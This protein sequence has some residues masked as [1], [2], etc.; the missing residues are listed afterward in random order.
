[1][2]STRSRRTF[3]LV[4]ATATLPLALT[5]CGMGDSE[6]DSSKD[7]AST[8]SAEKE[9]PAEDSADGAA[10]ASGPFGPGC[11]S[12]PKDGAGSFDGMAQDPVATAASN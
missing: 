6:S 3:A 7:K 1:M 4:V 10:Q 12:V 8:P 5:A 11:A 2:F 9:T